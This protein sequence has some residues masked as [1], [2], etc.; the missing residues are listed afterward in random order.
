MTVFEA[1]ILYKR[2]ILSNVHFYEVDDILSG[3]NRVTLTNAVITLAESAFEDSIQNFSLG[4]Q[5]I[6]IKL[7]NLAIHKIT[8]G[9]AVI[10]TETKSSNHFP[11]LI[12]YCIIE[13]KTNEKKVKKC[14]EDSITQFLNRFS[15][16]DITTKDPSKFKMFNIRLRKI[17][18]DLSLN[19]EDR[20]KFIL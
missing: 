12:I 6:L 16:Y 7:K 9:D 11:P 14:M 18:K 13:K 10:E 2:N 4:E 3:E 19:T 17:F 8:E 5:K 20:F 15:I 1:A